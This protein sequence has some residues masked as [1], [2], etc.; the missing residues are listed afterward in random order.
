MSLEG[1]QLGHYRLTSKLGS[2]GMGE[3]YL[4]QDTLIDRLV[5]VKI[6]RSQISSEPD[7]TA[8]RESAR[9]FQR[10]AQAIAALDH[11]Q[12]LP[13]FDFGEQNYDST[14]LTYMVMP[15]RQEGSLTDW[16]Q[17]HSRSDSLSLSTVAH[18]IQQ[19]AEALQHVHD[20]HIVHLDIKPSNILIRTNKEQPSYPNLLLTDFGIAKMAGTGTMAS[21]SVRG[22]PT[23]MAPEQWYGNTTPATDQ[24]A[25][26][27]MAYQ[28]LVGRPPFLGRQEQVM[29]QHLQIQPVP[30]SHFN[31]HLPRALDEVILHALAKK[32]E[33]RFASIAAFA[34]AFQQALDADPISID[35]P[36]SAPDIPFAAQDAVASASGVQS[37]T[38][39]MFAL[40][41]Q[42]TDRAISARKRFSPGRKV[43][44][45][46]LALLVIVGSMG[47]FY[48]IF[49]SPTTA[50]LA[51]NNFTHQMSATAQ[52]TMATHI[53]NATATTN[54]ATATAQISTQATA[55][56]AA[57]A[58]NLDPYPPTIGNHLAF[59]DPLSQPSQWWTEYPPDPTYGGACQFTN[60]T[61]QASQSQ[62]GHL[63]YCLASTP[64]LGNFAFEVQMTIIKGDCGGIVSRFDNTSGKFY[65]F[66]VCQDGTYTLNRYVDTTGANAR[67]LTT[68]GSSSAIHTG[69]NQSNVIAV[70]ANGS[71]LD[72][73][74][75]YQ[76]IDSVT[77]TS[78]SNGLIALA[79]TAKAN[80]TAVLYKNAKLWIF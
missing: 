68:N 44:L 6:V 75:N 79:V 23:Y 16:L 29:Y 40:P 38:P 35:A 45:I 22:T 61:Y 47:A 8:A 34:R 14:T 24:Y 2:G 30:P 12:I 72:L 67:S 66:E 37:S 46:L 62:G 17:Q 7:A 70:V 60:G 41:P 76:K 59:Y 39:G 15:F 50:N 3:V 25:L 57:S 48:F 65:D 10:E 1:T 52:A 71:T 63:F 77:D 55:Y 9:L 20:H 19:A 78:S 28:L 58:R 21:Q 36:E 80:P 73:Y 5:A 43:P 49:T 11:P 18:I 42:H 56:A 74:V 26:A 13:L 51:Q 31:P 54:A 27:V 64:K 69:L 4:A 32:P 33:Q 53:A